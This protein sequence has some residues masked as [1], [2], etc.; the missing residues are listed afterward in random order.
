MKRL[1]RRLVVDAEVK[2]LMLRMEQSKRLMCDA[3][4]AG[5]LDRAMHYRR[6]CGAACAACMELMTD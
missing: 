2:R 6:L 3:L 4:F 1:H 5:D